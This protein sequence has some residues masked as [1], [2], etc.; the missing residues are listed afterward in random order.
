MPT[1]SSDTDGP[2]YRRFDLTL[3]LGIPTQVVVPSVPRAAVLQGTALTVFVETPSGATLS[4]PVS[5]AGLKGPPTD[6]TPPVSG[7]ET[8]PVVG[9]GVTAPVVSPTVPVCANAA[10]AKNASA[11]ATGGV[12]TRIG[13]SFEM[14]RWNELSRRM[15]RL[16]AK[17]IQY[18]S[19]G[20][21]SN[22]QACRA[23]LKAKGK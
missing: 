7:G 8:A 10:D 17:S 16:P 19:R 3:P 23:A 2:P 21:R 6:G 12:I 9:A 18:L 11:A 15:F 14:L 22:L 20:S 1:G 5:V 13:A 4:K